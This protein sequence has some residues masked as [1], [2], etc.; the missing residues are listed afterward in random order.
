MQSELE[1]SSS[2]FTH[3]CHQQV[4]HPSHEYAWVWCGSLKNGVPAPHYL[5]GVVRG[6]STVALIQLQNVTLQS[7]Y[8][9]YK[10]NITFG[11]RTF[12]D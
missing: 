9:L 1:A 10:K 5:S 6:Q 2:V 12:L 8:S 3:S 4:S 11:Y 7:T